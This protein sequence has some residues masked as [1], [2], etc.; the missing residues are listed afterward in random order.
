MIMNNQLWTIVISKGQGLVTINDM[1]IK[2]T[3]NIHMYNYI[4]NICGILYIYI[5]IMNA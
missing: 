4:T 5:Y 3:R 2:Q 1:N